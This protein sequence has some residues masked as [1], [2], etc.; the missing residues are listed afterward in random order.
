M[1][2][3]WFPKRGTRAATILPQ[4]SSAAI[5]NLYCSFLDLAVFISLAASVA[6]NNA[7]LL[8]R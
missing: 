4:D 1:F 5:L 2:S 6:D 8:S 3:K 7:K